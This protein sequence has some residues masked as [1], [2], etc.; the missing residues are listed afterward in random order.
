MFNLRGNFNQVKS[1][2]GTS[3]NDERKGSQAELSSSEAEDVWTRSLCFHAIVG[4]SVVKRCFAQAAG[5]MEVGSL[6]FG[7]TRKQP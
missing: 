7:H 6:A 3:A 1:G 4:V 2:R 5:S